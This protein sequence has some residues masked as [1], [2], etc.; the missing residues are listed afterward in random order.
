MEF[1]YEI[2]LFANLK[3]EMREVIN[4]IEDVYEQLVLQYRY[5]HNN[6]DKRLRCPILSVDVRP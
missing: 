2:D 5:I 6:T 4:A 1:S 3:E